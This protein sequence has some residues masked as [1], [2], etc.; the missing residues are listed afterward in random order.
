[1]K[2]SNKVGWLAD[3]L[4]DTHIKLINRPQVNTHIRSI[5]AILK[6]CS[7]PNEA[8]I[9]PKKQKKMRQN[10]ATQARTGQMPPMQEL[11]NDKPNKTMKKKK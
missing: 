5:M 6:C 7:K 1:M 10:K 2:I 8:K 9:K 3:W 11:V 4:A